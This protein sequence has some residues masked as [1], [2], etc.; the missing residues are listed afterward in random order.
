[1]LEVLGRATSGN[2][3]KVL[4]LLEELGTPYKRHDY[5]RP[6]RAPRSRR[7]TRPST[8]RRKCRPCATASCMWESHTILRYVA[9]K[10]EAHA[11]YPRD[12]A[13][14]SQVERW[15][16]WTLASLNVAY[17]AGFK[18]AAAEQ[19]SGRPPTAVRRAVAAGRAPGGPALGRGRGLL[20]G[21]HLPGASGAPL[22]EVPHPKP[23]LE[24]LRQWMARIEQRPA[25][26]AAV[27]AG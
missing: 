6:S 10:Q 21:R 20:P 3:Q 24:H 13:A 16:D 15:M 7:N 9:N 4:F 27:A 17:L 1:M 2:V 18:E 26:A 25:F 5:A 14:R 8:P 12:P 11:L 19:L 22:P 23:E